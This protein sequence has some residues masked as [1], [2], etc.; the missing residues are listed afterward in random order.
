LRQ[1]GQFFGGCRKL[2]LKR[3]LRKPPSLA[4]ARN[5]GIESGC[6]K[7]DVNGPEADIAFGAYEDAVPTELLM[8][9]D[10]CRLILRVF[11]H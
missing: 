11:D 1:D 3:A 2:Y 9:A 8:I 7:A 5:Y 4:V 6:S 10:Q